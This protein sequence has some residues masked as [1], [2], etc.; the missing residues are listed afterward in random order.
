MF[1]DIISDLFQTLE[2]KFQFWGCRE[3]FLLTGLARLTA[4]AK[5]HWPRPMAIGRASD[6]FRPIVRSGRSSDLADR[7]DLADA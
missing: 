1:G 3:F 7:A 6:G 4:L 2:L 5:S